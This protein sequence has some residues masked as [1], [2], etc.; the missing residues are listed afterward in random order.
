M[1]N[2]IILVGFSLLINCGFT[3]SQEQ[4]LDDFEPTAEFD[5][6]HV[7]KVEEDSLQSSFIIWVKHGVKEHYHADHT[8]NLVVVSGK[9]EMT[10]GDSTFIIVKGDYVNIPKG[11]KHSVTKV[12]SKEPL[13]VLSIQS[14]YFDGNDRVFTKD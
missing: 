13:K 10:L 2:A 8:E 14:P 5:N 1:M 7:Y 6:I 9:A 3:Y 12:M 11:T 4:D